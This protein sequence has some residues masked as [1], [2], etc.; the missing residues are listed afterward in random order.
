MRY[1]TGQP[2]RITWTVRDIAGALANPGAQTLTLLRPDL[3]TQVYASPSTTGTGLFHQDVPVSDLTPNGH[4]QY[5]AV[6]TGANA[7]VVSG[8]FDVYDPFDTEVLTIEDARAVCNLETDEQDAELEVYIAA[9]TEAIEAD[10]GPVGRRTITETVYPS[11]GVLLLRQ[12]PV[13]SLTSVTPYLSAALTVGSL[14]FDAN[15]GIVYPGV[16]TGF[17]A[18][19]YD[20]VYVAGR[21]QVSASV[22]L[23]ARKTLKH[24]WSPDQY[25]ASALPR[26]GFGG[27]EDLASQAFSFVKSYGV[28]ELL[29]AE[30]RPPAVA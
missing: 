12:T 18:G 13:L 7:G 9:T 16:Y 23:A 4:F 6:A 10:I 30:K 20:V 21:A 2:V 29:R 11:S 17:W 27:E 8:A 26:A 5:K 14:T 3:T 15:S 24:L 19:R 28:Q 25:G 22:N 1:P